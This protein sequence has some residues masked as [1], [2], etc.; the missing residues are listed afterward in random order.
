MP[1]IVALSKSPLKISQLVSD[2]KQQLWQAEPF[3][4]SGP[5]PLFWPI[6]EHTGS[7]EH[8]LAS[9]IASLINLLK[10]PFL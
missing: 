2:N 7:A 6:S 3:T 4:L 10:S 8:H 9:S 1:I 5:C